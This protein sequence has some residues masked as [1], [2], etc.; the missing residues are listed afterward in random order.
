[1]PSPAP[2]NEALSL[3]APFMVSLSRGRGETGEDV[4]P[5]DDRR[6]HGIA[7]AGRKRERSTYAPPPRISERQDRDIA[8]LM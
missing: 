7:L 3:R 1:M 6:G 2:P 5:A 4:A 8:G